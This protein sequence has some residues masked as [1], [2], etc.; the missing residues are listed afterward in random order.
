MNAVLVAKSRKSLELQKELHVDL[1]QKNGELER[2]T[3]DLNTALIEARK[4]T[5]LK[6]NELEL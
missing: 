2:R 1:L 6:I 5:A 3:S 4:E